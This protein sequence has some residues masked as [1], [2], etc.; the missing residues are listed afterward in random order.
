MNSSVSLTEAINWGN[1]AKIQMF[2]LQTQLNEAQKANNAP[3]FYKLKNEVILCRI[4]T[5]A[6]M[7]SLHKSDISFLRHE[8]ITILFSSLTH[9]QNQAV[10]RGQFEESKFTDPQIQK[11]I[12]DEYSQLDIL[13]QKIEKKSEKLLQ[14][15]EKHSTPLGEDRIYKLNDETCCHAPEC[16]ETKFTKSLKKCGQCKKVLYCSQECQKKDW[17]A[18]KLVCK[19]T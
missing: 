2:S 7:R 8:K 13:L 11:A 14:F 9:L 17:P 18:H 10:T 19:K 3:L 6:E 1:E 16:Q 12:D 15:A 5:Q 4:K